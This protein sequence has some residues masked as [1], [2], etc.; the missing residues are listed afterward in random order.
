MLIFKIRWFS[1]RFISETKSVT[2][3]F[4]FL[5]LTQVT[6]YLTAVKLRKNLLT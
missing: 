6:H 3:I 5:F 1:T 2:P 4:F